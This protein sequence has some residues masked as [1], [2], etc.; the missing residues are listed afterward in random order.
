MRARTASRSI[1]AGVTLLVASTVVV[2]AAVITVPTDYPTIQEAVDASGPGDTIQVLPG[3]YEGR[4]WI[5]E[6]DLTLRSVSG[7]AVT[8]L[9]QGE[10]SCMISVGGPL[11][12]DT[13]IEGFTVRGYRSSTHGGAMSLDAP[14]VVRGCVFEDNVVENLAEP[15]V[16]R[17]AAI[18]AW[19]AVRLEGNVFRGNEAGRYGGAVFIDA[20]SGAPPVE[21]VENLFEGNR[22]GQASALGV[23]LAIGGE[24]RV[25]R[26]T[27]VDNGDYVM[28]LEGDGEIIGNVFSDHVGDGTGDCAIQCWMTEPVRAGES[29][30]FD[31][32]VSCNV[33]DLPTQASSCV[34]VLLDD[35]ATTEPWTFYFGDPLFCDREGGDYRIHPESPAA[36]LD[37]GP[38]GAFETS[39]AVVDVADVAIIGARTRVLGARPHRAGDE[40]RLVVAEGTTGPVRMEVYE[41]SGRRVAT[42]QADAADGSTALVWS[43]GAAAIGVHFIRVVSAGW[44]ETHRVA[45]IP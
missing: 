32:L 35:C 9:E 29:A 41:V 36:N 44:T 15:D 40:I 28:A 45:L 24:A 12:R 11:G 6:H 19:A 26:N 2:H 13:V 1:A 10:A 3:V 34:D 42:I 8:I 43:P 16:G 23:R 4:T 18:D 39:C 5:H 33:F 21:V 7:A 38:V 31:Q 27:F 25:E 17:G 22:A 14:V 30:M 20:G 37:C